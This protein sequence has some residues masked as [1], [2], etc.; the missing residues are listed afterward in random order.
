[1][2]NKLLYITNTRLPSEKANSYQSMQMCS[3]FSKFYDR[4]EMWVPR[5][6]SGLHSANEDVFD[7]YGVRRTFEIKYFSTVD[8]TIL[9][10]INQ[11]VWANVKSIVYGLNILYQVFKLNNL[12]ID[13]FTRDLYVLKFLLLGRNFGLLDNKIF[14][15]AHRFSKFIIND[16]KKCDG[17][18]VINE[19]L[20]IAHKKEGIDNILVAHDG[21]NFDEYRNLSK[22]KHIKKDVYKLVYTG[23]LFQWKGVHTL[24]DSLNFTTK[25]VELII[26]G[27]VGKTLDDFKLFVKNSGLSNVKLIGHV[28]KKDTIKYVEQA[29][30]L[31]LPNSSKDIMSLYTSPI[32]LFE[33]M[34]ANRPII[35][36]NLP[37]ICEILK[38]NV[39]AILFDPDNAKDLAIKIDWVLENN[40][41]NI[42]D[43]AISD[44][45]NYGWD[46]R[47]ENIK[48]FLDST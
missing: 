44:V 21:V 28:K 45:Q 26:V 1:M 46:R 17:V 37:S 7:F 41:K 36:S 4:V 27:G 14:Y 24:V 16:L 8:S 11:F 6:H 47:A 19:Y 38:N 3:N 25:N 18:I 12:S 5:L 2:K 43:K 48:L 42:V 29:D 13:I 9:S 32:K 40:C 30:I 22:Y 15:E 39:N 34:A 31:F 20:S 23:N 10:R 33:Y 35:A